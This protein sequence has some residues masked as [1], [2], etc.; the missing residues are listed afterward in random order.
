VDSPEAFALHLAGHFVKTYQQVSWADVEIG[1]AAWRRID[2]AGRPHATAFESAGD[3]LRRASVTVFRQGHGPRVCGGV[4][5]LL[6]LKTTDSAFVGFVRDKYATLP[7]VTDRIL[8]TELAAEW[9]FDPPDADYNTAYDRIRRAMLET[10]ARHKSES[11]Q[12]TLYDMGAAAVAA[13][14]AVH[15]IHLRMPNKHRVP[16]DFKPFG[17]KFEND[18]FVTTDEPS[19]EISAHLQRE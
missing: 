4:S 9:N 12:Q 8:A 14:P 5:N 2:V 1:Q 13:E 7:E 19:G 18:V 6:I 17:L 11:V 16:F 15:S 10:F 3:E